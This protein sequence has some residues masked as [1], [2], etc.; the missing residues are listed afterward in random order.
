MTTKIPTPADLKAQAEQLTQ[1][2]SKAMDQYVR[3]G[4]KV[5]DEMFKLAH[6][7]MDSYR[8]LAS[9]ILDVYLS[10]INNNLSLIMKRLTGVTVILAGIGAVGRWTSAGLASK[11]AF[12][13][14]ACAAWAVFTAVR[15][16]NSSFLTLSIE[17]VTRTDS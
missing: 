17:D 14:A 4:A 5:Q 12:L 11:V 10:T 8:D 7:Q 6:Q 16:I 15:W 2:A 1:N 13:T 3:M 9:G